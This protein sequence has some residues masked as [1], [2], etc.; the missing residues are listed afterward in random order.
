M[1]ITSINEALQVYNK[2]EDE[3]DKIRNKYEKQD[4][5]LKKARD[6]IEQYMLSAMKEMGLQSFE[7]PNE[8]VAT[9]KE[10]R[11]FGG[12]DWALIWDFVVR[13]N[14]VDMLQKR[15]LD[16]AV[17]RYLDENGTLP[18]GVSTEC[19]KIIVVTKRG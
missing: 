12:S 10:K 9:I 14:C 3:R 6:E 16:T 5:A 7:I 15:L 17:Q 19:R 8:G 1:K 18:P 2:I 4:S 13:N 11:R